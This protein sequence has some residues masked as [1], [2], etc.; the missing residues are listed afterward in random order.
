VD[1]NPGTGAQF[2]IE[3]DG[4][5]PVVTRPVSGDE[6]NVSF[7]I[8]LYPAVETPVTVLTQDGR[9]A[10][11]VSVGLEIP[12]VRSPSWRPGGFGRI[13]EGI[14]NNVLTT[15]HA[16]RFSLPPDESI[17]RVIAASPD[18]Y[19]ESTRVALVSNLTMRLQPWG[20][21]EGSFISGGKPVAGRILTI[22]QIRPQNSEILRFDVETD[23]EGHFLFPEVPP[24]TF[25]L[26]ER[27]APIPPR[28]PRRLNVPAMNV[29]LGETTA[30]QIAFY[31]AN[32]RLT[33]PANFEMQPNWT[34]SVAASQPQLD[35]PLRSRE[36]FHDAGNGTW[37]ANELPA[38]DYT[39][40]AIVGEPSVNGLPGV[41]RLR[42]EASFTVP[43][44]ASDGAV[45][46]GGLTLQPVQ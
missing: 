22:G 25:M 9:P 19:A 26:F 4:Y 2:K 43:G 33:F 31:T 40:T 13:P 34:I 16:G 29:R 14:Y 38:G 32:V 44:N 1:D 45:D 27:E 37:Q 46:L 3:A 6:R 24:G 10:T 20:R 41:V 21:I 8:Q 42:A 36:T 39:L 5:A 7:D 28:G 30:V 17:A 35:R 11:N 12:G 23:Q 15:D 18:G